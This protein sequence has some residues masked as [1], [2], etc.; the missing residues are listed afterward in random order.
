M[1]SVSRYSDRL[2]SQP[3]ALFFQESRQKRIDNRRIISFLETS[4]IQLF[5]VELM[6][7]AGEGSFMAGWPIRKNLHH[8]CVVIA[9]TRYRHYVLKV[10]AGL[11]LKPKFFPG[12]GPEACQT[13]LHRYGKAFLRHVGKSQDLL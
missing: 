2:Y 1:D 7:K 10:T 6:S 3:R 13:L 9:V 11:S 4:C 8:Q 12:T 5:F